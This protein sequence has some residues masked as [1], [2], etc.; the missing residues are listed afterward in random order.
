MLLPLQP[1][2][3][4]CIF[5]DVHT[6]VL[7]PVAHCAFAQCTWT[8][9][10]IRDGSSHLRH[11]T[12]HLLWRH[13]SDFRQALGDVPGF[14]YMDYYEEALKVKEGAHMPATGLSVDRRVLRICMKFVVK[15]IS[16]RA[17]LCS[18]LRVS[19]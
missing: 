6:G 4:E 17:P 2:S 9:C 19:R 7:L 5:E 16:A 11:L 1:D 18:E 12:N 13:H 14:E 15:N 3:T 10:N 8:C